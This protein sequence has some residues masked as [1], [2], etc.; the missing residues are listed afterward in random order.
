M[1][2]LAIATR[3]LFVTVCGHSAVLDVLLEYGGDISEPD[4][5]QAYPLHYAAQMIRS[6]RDD[7]GNLNTEDRGEMK[8]IKGSIRLL[9]KLLA[10]HASPEVKD[11]DQRTPIIWAASAGM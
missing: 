10:N 6:P 1:A 2:L 5:H 11:K 9:K 4:R 3:L 7:S 8:N